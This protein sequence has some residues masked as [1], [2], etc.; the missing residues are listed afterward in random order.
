MSLMQMSKS[1]GLLPE[2]GDG[3]VAAWSGLLMTPFI[4]AFHDTVMKMASSPHQPA[5]ALQPDQL[6]QASQDTDEDG[7]EA[8]DI[9]VVSHGQAPWSFGCLKL[10]EKYDSTV[11]APVPVDVD[12]KKLS[13]F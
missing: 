6:D 8:K 9:D 12:F 4:G 10:S 11:S 7:K 3:A 2:V 13:W 5:R 1:C